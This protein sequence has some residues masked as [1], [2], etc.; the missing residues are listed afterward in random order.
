MCLIKVVSALFS[1]VYH[2]GISM[3]GATNTSN[4]IVLLILMLSLSSYVT[5]DEGVIEV[6]GTAKVSVVPDMATFLFSIKG[7]GKELSSLKGEIDVKTA[8]L[9][10]FCKKLGVKTKKITSS[11]MSIR[12]QYNYKTRLF[13]GYEVSRDIKVRLDELDRYPDLVNGAIDSG[14]TTIKNIMLDTMDRDALTRKALVSAMHAARSKA[15]ILA[16]ASE[17]K[18]GKIMNVKE[19]GAPVE[20]SSYLYKS[21]AQSGDLSQGAFE[22]GEIS[23]SATVSVKYAVE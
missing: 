22:P 1:R 10:T 6:M 5:A 21:R 18:L 11:E 17:V 16:K 2:G 23:V 15:E 13:L 20:R 19:V 9:V 4:L 3:P 14:I 7:R 8:T 12:P